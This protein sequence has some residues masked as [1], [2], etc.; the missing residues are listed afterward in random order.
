M[1][2]TARGILIEVYSSK[3]FH[4]KRG[5]SEHTNAGVVHGCAQNPKNNAHSKVYI[6]KAQTDTYHAILH[7]G[8]SV[9]VN[10]NRV[11][12]YFSCI[13]IRSNSLSVGRPLLLFTISKLH[14]NECSKFKNADK[15]L[16]PVPITEGKLGQEMVVR[17]TDL[18]N[19]AL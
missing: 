19:C 12:V 13:R 14:E 17:G 11:G 9:L 16:L 2:C 10:L 4:N 15:Y 8:T 6:P 1:L 3:P 5:T 7:S 18:I